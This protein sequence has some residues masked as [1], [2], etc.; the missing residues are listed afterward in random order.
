[1]DGRLTTGAYLDDWLETSVRPRL[2]PRTA[3][4]YAWVC[5]KYLK[6]AIGRIRLAR[7]GPEHIQ[8]MLSNLTARGDLSPTTVRYA[9]T[10]LRIALGRALKAGHVARNAA[11]LI[12]PPAKARHEMNPLTADQV[13]TLLDE[14]SG[15]RLGPLYATAVALGL[16]KGELLALRWADIDRDAGTITIT[17]TLQN[18]GLAQTKTKRSRRTVI[19]PRMVSVAGKHRSCRQPNGSAA[20]PRWQHGDFVFASKAGTRWGRATSRA[21]SM[22]LSSGA[23]FR[24]SVS[25]ISATRAQHC[26]WSRARTWPSCHDCSGTRTSQ[27]LPTSTRTSHEGCSSAQLIAWMLLSAGPQAPD[28]EFP[29]VRFGVKTE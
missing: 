22:L 12:D 10:V 4:S 27:P 18:T 23:A 13:A 20:G 3:E 19:M 25:M 5:A 14:T 15:D 8:K 24:T 28:P 1:M 2:R 16:R 7:L 11:T 17:N 26:S 21:H 29:G 9:Y 6:P